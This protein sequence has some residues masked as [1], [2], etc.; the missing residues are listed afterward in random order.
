MKEQVNVQ[1]V[2]QKIAEN[3]DLYYIDLALEHFEDYY[4]TTQNQIKHMQ[5]QCEK[6]YWIMKSLEKLRELAKENPPKPPEFQ[7][8]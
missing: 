5:K 8:I 2:M 1:E 6:T 7:K 4:S 3:P